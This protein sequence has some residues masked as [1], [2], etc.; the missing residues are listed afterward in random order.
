MV[1]DDWRGCWQLRTGGRGLERQAGVRFPELGLG[2]VAEE[3]VRRRAAARR[4]RLGRVEEVWGGGDRVNCGIFPG[5]FCGDA[6][7]STET[8]ANLTSRRPFLIYRR[9]ECSILAWPELP[10]GCWGH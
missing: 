9:S 10:W 5:K 1:A 3:G 6:L 2:G 7:F 8:A 4:W